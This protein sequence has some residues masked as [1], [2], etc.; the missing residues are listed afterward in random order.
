MVTEENS[1]KEEHMGRRNSQQKVDPRVQRERALSRRALLQVG[2]GVATLGA[3]GVVGTSAS[4]LGRDESS[5]PG[6]RNEAPEVRDL[7]VG[8]QGLVLFSGMA[9]DGMFYVGT[10]NRSPLQV[11]GYDTS[12]GRVT[13][14]VDVGSTGMVKSMVERDGVMF[15]GN[16]VPNL[17][18]A[19]EAS[20]FRWDMTDPGAK[21]EPL[22]RP[23]L[24][25][26][27]VLAVA[28]DGM[29]YA[30]GRPARLY[31][32]DPTTGATESLGLIGSNGTMARAVAATE[33]LVFVASE[34]GLFQVNRTT[35]EVSL[36]PLPPEIDPGTVGWLGVL[37][38]ELYLRGLGGMAVLSLDDFSTVALGPSVVNTRSQFMAVEDDVYVAGHDLYRYSR[39]SNSVEKVAELSPHNFAWGLGHAAGVIYAGMDDGTV[40][41]YDVANGHAERRS[42]LDVGAQSDPVLGMSIA[43]GNGRVYVGGTQVVAAH[44]AEVGNVSNLAIPGEVKSMLVL[45]DTLFAPSYSARGMWTHVPGESPIQEFGFPS[46]PGRPYRYN[47]PWDVAWDGVHERV[48][49]TLEAD[50]GGGALIVYAPDSGE[51]EERLDPFG[52]EE[53]LRSLA[54]GSDGMAYVASVHGVRQAGGSEPNQP[55]HLAAWNPLSPEPDWVVQPDLSGGLIQS[56]VAG[57]GVLYGLAYEPVSGVRSFFA[58]D[59]SAREVLHQQDAP[60]G[61]GS[62]GPQK[63][64]L[65]NGTMY[66]VTQEAMYRV[67]LANYEWT[68]LVENL[69]DSWYGRPDLAVDEDGILYTLR[70]RRLISVRDVAS[71]TD[72]V[73]SLVD[74]Y[75]DSGRVHQSVAMR[76]RADLSVMERR[77]GRP[78]ERAWERL[79]ALIDEVGSPEVRSALRLAANALP[80]AQVR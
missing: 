45:E 51:W 68:P 65:A 1:L 53:S 76:L 58:F 15:T 22:A 25:R 3:T 62:A 41:S 64:L 48:L 73:Q 75:L 35:R 27:I 47:R 32:I 43:A 10:R 60:H 80:A 12:E 63:L 17:L 78:A 61:Q 30:T 6:A 5:S 39:V 67:S 4:A 50:N 74:Y 37:G 70:D 31:E 77:S 72:E 44:E 79:S 2:G 14:A 57:D 54:V 23:G 59:T 52:D 49:V 11:L 36:V 28:P 71:A 7:G 42:L 69:G 66:H 26:N 40:V 34:D 56:M 13:D 38:G 29:L 16:A 18:S 19:G 55:G 20:I 46:T 9:H 21:P 24:N 33:T 8:V